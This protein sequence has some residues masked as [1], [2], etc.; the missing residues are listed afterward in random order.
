MIWISVWIQDKIEGFLTFP[1]R[2][3]LHRILCCHLAN[4]TEKWHNVGGG[5]RSLSALLAYV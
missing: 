3:N 4:T 2:A 5:W 1:N